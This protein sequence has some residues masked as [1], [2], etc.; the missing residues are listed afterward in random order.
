MT[1]AVRVVIGTDRSCCRGGKRHSESGSSLRSRSTNPLIAVQNATVIQPNV[2]AKSTRIAVSIPVI[3]LARRISNIMLTPAN[4][5]RKT[6][7]KKMVRR[8][9][10]AA[11]V[12]AS[13]RR[14]EETKEWAELVD[15][16]GYPHRVPGFR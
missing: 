3:P 7:P 1:T 8:S 15:V 13:G 16:I 11:Q 5:V 12:P 14:E 6:R 9:A 10:G 2:T 4:V